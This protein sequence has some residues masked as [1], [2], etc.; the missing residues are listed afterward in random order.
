LENPLKMMILLT[1]GTGYI[2]SHTA[3]ACLNAGHQV[4][5]LDN[6]CNSHRDAVSK[7]QQI[8]QQ[9]VSFVEGDIRDT[10]CVFETL[11]NFKVEAVIH[12]AGLKSV[13]DS[14]ENPIDYY[15]NNVGGSISLLQA[16]QQANVKKMV[17][18]SSA[19]V[20]GAPEYLPY[21]EK[22]PTSPINVY[23]RTKLQIEW[24]LQDLAASDTD[25]R[26]LALRYFNPVG[27]HES[28][29]IGENPVGIPNNLMP[30]LAK[31]AAKELPSLNIFGNDYPTKDGTGERD[32]I[33]VMDLAEGHIAA[34]QYLTAQSGFKTVNLGTGTAYSVLELIQ[35]FENVNHLKIP[36]QIAPRRAGDLPCYF[37]DASLAQEL[38][39][40]SAKRS[41]AD[42]CY[43]TWQFKKT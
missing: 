35:T 43:S 26:I 41:L 30:Y 7:I 39:Q 42:M 13:K 17:F 36:Y 11:V 1:G 28:G 25:W 37:A 8:T 18:S 15:H 31:V 16:M 6:L 27:A 24:M 29:L 14:T 32:Y 21:D 22:H 10:Q 38:F 5:I 3:V 23:G 40:W 20:Y 34:L 19:T 9:S 33:H 12:L 2:G 4:V